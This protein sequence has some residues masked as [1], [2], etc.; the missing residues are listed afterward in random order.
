MG[1][2]TKIQWTDSTH[3]FWIG[4]EKVSPG[5]KFCYAERDMSRWDKN[6][7]SVTKTKGFNKP[8][9]WKKEP[10]LVFVNSW[11]DF[12]IEE[13]DPWRDEAWE[14]IK[15]TPEF[16]YQ[17]L[18]KRPER[19][20]QCLPEDWGDGYPNV[21]LGVSIETQEQTH[22]LITLNQLKTTSSVFKTF[23]SA[24]P[25]L[26]EIIFDNDGVVLSYQFERL[27]WM[28]I[29]GESGN[30][31]GKWLYRPCEMSWIMSILRQCKA[32]GIPVFVKQLGTHLAKELGLKDSHG[33]NADEWP[34]GE[35]LR[36]FPTQSQPLNTLK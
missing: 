4:C 18:T 34:D 6:F 25:L 8:L 2:K 10:K 16:T 36:E 31:T 7:R 20:E 24:E 1:E 3:N 32:H 14:I 9:S 11:S 35:W 28:I 27:D 19:I 26:E 30:E 23:V 12:F 22:R 33:G 21:W 17:I 5:C 13:A 29:G 15:Q